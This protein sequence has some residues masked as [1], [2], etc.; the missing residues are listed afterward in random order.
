[1]SPRLPP[2]PGPGGLL[3]FPVALQLGVTLGNVSSL[4][5]NFVLLAR[6]G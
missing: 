1:M 2:A 3:G 6:S 4:K 5:F